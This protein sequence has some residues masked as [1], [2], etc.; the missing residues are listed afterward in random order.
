MADVIDLA[1]RKEIAEDLEHAPGLLARLSD[2][3]LPE[4]CPTHGALLHEAHQYLAAFVSH[5]KRLQKAEV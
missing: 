2:A 4:V 3:S 5:T 1:L